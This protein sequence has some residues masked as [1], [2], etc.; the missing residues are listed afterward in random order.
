MSNATPIS[1]NDKRE[2]VIRLE[3][4]Y[5]FLLTAFQGMQS[6]FCMVAV[7]VLKDKTRELALNVCNENGLSVPEWVHGNE[8]T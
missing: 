4:D 7:E 1:Q 8:K 3:H 5:H 6:R 2:H